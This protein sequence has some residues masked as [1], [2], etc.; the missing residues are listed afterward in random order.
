MTK[1]TIKKAISFALILL[2]V[3]MASCKNEIEEELQNSSNTT[4][5]SEGLPTNA[6]IMGIIDLEDIKN[7]NSLRSSNSSFSDLRDYHH[8]LFFKDIRIYTALEDKSEDFVF[9]K[10][11]YYG[12]L[13]TLLNDESQHVYNYLYVGFT[14]NYEEALCEIHL[15]TRDKP[16]PYNIP[17][18]QR[19][20]GTRKP[21]GLDLYSAK[22]YLHT[23]INTT[24]DLYP[25]LYGV[26]TPESITVE[27]LA[28]IMVVA[29]E[30]GT[31]APNRID[32]AGV[33]YRKIDSN[34]R[35]E[36][37]PGNLNANKKGTGKK[38][39]IYTRDFY[40]N[41]SYNKYIIKN[42]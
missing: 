8:Q 13:A 10:G 3:S 36:V 5:S 16:V 22:L 29:F 34:L 1:L 17:Y 40:R 39:Y 33:E 30:E 6:T 42:K 7:S 21:L 37:D 18:E 35:K 41:S 19:F 24:N 32:L 23:N 38:V 12:K 25:Y 2:G 27:P 31:T 14:T 26:Y 4:E 28:G 20:I 11:V 9:D 15:I